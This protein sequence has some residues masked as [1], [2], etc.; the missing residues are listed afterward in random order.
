MQ[1]WWK[2]ILA[3]EK[4]KLFAEAGE[5]NQKW[6]GNSHPSHIQTHNSKFKTKQINNPP[7]K[8]AQQTK[9]INLKSKTRG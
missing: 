3:E 1:K 2:V 7:V 8:K 9:M 5:F 6:S 4:T